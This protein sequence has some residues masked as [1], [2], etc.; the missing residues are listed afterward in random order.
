[1]KQERVAISEI[2]KIIGEEV[3][4]KKLFAKMS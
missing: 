1:M 3:S 4:Y 2:G